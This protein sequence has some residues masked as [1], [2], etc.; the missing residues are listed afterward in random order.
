MEREVGEE[1]ESGLLAATV[2]AVARFDYY[3][4]YV[5]ERNVDP[6]YRFSGLAS[7]AW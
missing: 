1:H 2:W 4:F 6:T 5:I 7:V 3:A